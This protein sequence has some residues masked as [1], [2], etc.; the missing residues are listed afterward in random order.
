M[1]DKAALDIVPFPMAHL[2]ANGNVVSCNRMFEQQLGLAPD[3]KKPFFL[4]DYVGAVSASGQM[5]NILSN[6][7]KSRSPVTSSVKLVADNS[8]QLDL[9]MTPAP[10]GSGCLLQISS[11]PI[12]SENAGM[13]Q[14]QSASGLPVS[15]ASKQTVDFLSGL[16]HHLR[17]P[18]SGVLGIAD[19]LAE[20]E[21]SKQQATY[22]DILSR[23]CNALMNLVDE[24]QSITLLEQGIMQ[25]EPEN[26]GV[27][28]VAQKVLDQFAMTSEQK[29]ISTHLK[30][31]E[32]LP[33]L[34]SLDGGKLSQILF[35]LLDNAYRYTDQGAVTLSI[36]FDDDPATKVLTIC[37]KDTGIG[38]AKERL[39]SLF[40]R[41][42]KAEA[43]PDASYG[44][45]GLGLILCHKLVELMGGT[46]QV[47]SGFGHGTSFVVQVP[48]GIA[49]DTGT[50]TVNQSAETIARGGSDRAAH[51][52][53]GNNGVCWSILIAE[54]NPVNQ[55]LFRTV[56]ERFGHKV[57]VVGNGQEAVAKVQMGISYD[58]ILM[59]ISMPV[60]DGLDATAMIRSLYGDVGS[61]PILALTAHALE[62]DREK[63]IN[64]GMDG[65]Q[66]KPVD[67]MT[68]LKAIADVIDNRNEYAHMEQQLASRAP[69]QSERP[70][71]ALE[72]WQRSPRSDH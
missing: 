45:T 68:L 4:E 23:S 67:P 26:I 2:D 54:D 49:S 33:A 41:G 15:A 7:I 46:I 20:T 64:A 51:G 27:V 70:E 25:L 8:Q 42:E 22:V 29:E 40:S 1:I 57:T 59:D 30:A 71:N 58:V 55:M 43:S 11:Q 69:E 34:L 61:T 12:I 52:P 48:V 14:T 44:N 18:V 13:D 53:A 50:E 24:I 39:P 9:I 35:I 10:D 17:T 31:E 72:S 38:I 5:E 66:S 65:Y 16:S 56:L 36:D 19:L 47:D 28:D 32:N 63:F 3:C 6:C 62:G 37:V 21:L 60:M